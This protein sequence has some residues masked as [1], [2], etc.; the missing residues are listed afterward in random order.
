MWMNVKFLPKMMQGV[1]FHSSSKLFLC[2]FVLCFYSANSF[3]QQIP[4]SV[5]KLISE[6]G[7][8]Q[9]IPPD[10]SWGSIFEFS[11]QTIIKD[12]GKRSPDGYISLTTSY[13]F[14]HKEEGNS[15]YYRIIIDDRTGR[16]NY[17]T[18]GVL[19]ISPDR[20]VINEINY[21]LGRPSTTVYKKDEGRKHHLIQ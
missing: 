9:V 20:N 15:I 4:Y 21:T 7:T 14:H 1:F 18:G 12:P 5:T 16:Q 17:Y 8:E 13:G 11:G 6:D 10:R 19:V 2:F 3:S